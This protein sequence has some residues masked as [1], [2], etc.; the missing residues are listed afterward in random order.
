MIIKKN[1]Y[2]FEV[3]AYYSVEIVVLDGIIKNIKRIDDVVSGYVLPGLIDSHVHIESSMLV[4]VRFA[5]LCYR[6]GVVSVVADPHEIA[7]VMGL[8]GVEFMI[9]NAK[10][11]KLKFNFMVPSCVPATSFETSGAILG[12]KDIEYLMGSDNVKGLGEMMNYP[13]VLF[14]DKFVFEKLSIAKKFNKPIDGHAPAGTGSN[15]DKYIS[16]GISTDHEASTY[17]EAVEKISKGMMIQIREGSAAKNLDSL[18]RLVK[19]YPDSV[20]LCSDDIHPDDFVKG[21]INQHVKRLIHN[22]V[23]FKDI[24]K[25][26][27]FNP[28]IHYNLSNVGK[29]KIGD[30]ADFIIVNNLDD[31][32]IEK[33]Y[34]DGVCV[35][36]KS[37]EVEL[38][39]NF[40]VVNNFNTD[41]LN[42]DDIKVINLDKSLLNV[43]EIIDGELLTKHLKMEITPGEIKSNT[44]NDILKIVVYNRY[45]KSKP[46]V[47]FIKGFNLKSG[48]IAL[49]VAHDSHN[50]ICV[51]VNDEEITNAINL[52]VENKGGI[53]LVNN[54]YKNSLKLEVA[55]IMTNDSPFE[56]ANKYSSLNSDSKN[57]GCTLKSPFMTLSFMALL[58]IPKL[59]LSDL[60][61]FDG[62]KFN[63]VEL[64]E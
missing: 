12:V 11:T 40:S 39:Y 3:G 45:K 10:E 47:G 7:N 46:A 27:F 29:L 31:F 14:D 37:V 44:N 30:P 25:A 62:E 35:F 13:G 48:A 61:L 41:K 24:Y 50:I 60:G 54:E 9:Q 32:D 52:I 55:G 22:K 51:G 49:S 43:I 36:D 15:L 28:I 34:I 2:D 4:P 56:V 16:A 8:S 63:F 1:L 53:C 20:M 57:I 64:M 33:T 17:E 59:K 58:V 23:P 6:N 21:Y 19:E 18:W 5:E 38:E 26:A 42:V